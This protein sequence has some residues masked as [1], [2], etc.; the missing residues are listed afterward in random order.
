LALSFAGADAQ[1]VH[2]RIQNAVTNGNTATALRELRALEAEVND[3]FLANN[4]DYLAARLAERAGDSADA[5]R[6]FEL[7]VRRGSPLSEYALSHLA[8]IARSTGD[9]FLERIYLG[10]LLF[11]Y[12][13]S[14]VVEAAAR[15]LA[16]SHFESGSY[17]L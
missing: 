8:R 10:E 6:R 2:S 17:G 15:R 5:M 16:R 1:D 14:L 12:P 11:F 7:V 9:L 13:E 3:L 4:Y